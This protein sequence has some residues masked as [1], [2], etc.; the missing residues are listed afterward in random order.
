[1]EGLPVWF[2]VVMQ[3]GAFGLLTVVV[4][5]IAPRFL[6]EARKERESRDDRFE[7]ITVALREGFQAA[8]REQTV[9]LERA[10][11]SVCRSR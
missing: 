11:T 6:A 1:M 8:L 2:N 10:L 9:A 4:V 3:L 7:K 5:V